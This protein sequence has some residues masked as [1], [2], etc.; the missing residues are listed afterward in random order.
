MASQAK[1]T[2]TL[3]VYQGADKAMVF[4]GGPLIDGLFQAAHHLSIAELEALIERL[5]AAKTEI[6]TR[7]R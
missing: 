6:N 3:T 5:Q 2:I 1:Q 4:D 7:F